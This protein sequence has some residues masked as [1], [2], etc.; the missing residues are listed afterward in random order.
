MESSFTW[1]GVATELMTVAI[2]VTKEIVVW[3]RLAFQF[4]NSSTFVKHDHRIV[5]T[6][7]LTQRNT[8]FCY[9]KHFNYPNNDHNPVYNFNSPEHDDDNHHDSNNDNA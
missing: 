2:T 6:K 4:R 1:I 5:S 7:I 3:P 8:I 9:R